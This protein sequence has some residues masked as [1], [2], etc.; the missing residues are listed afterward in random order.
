MKFDCPECHRPIEVEGRFIGK[1]ASCP[2]CGEVIQVRAGSG[3]PPPVAVPV[4]TAPAH[5]P[6]PAPAGKGL[7]VALLVVAVVIALLLFRIERQLA[8]IPTVEDWYEARDEQVPPDMTATERR[9]PVVGVKGGVEVDGEAKV[10][11]INRLDDPV[12][13]R[14]RN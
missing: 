11:V 2:Y 9:L 3:D 14:T 13:V 4:A 1:E 8:A 12:P 7:Q 5:P 6:A 10:R